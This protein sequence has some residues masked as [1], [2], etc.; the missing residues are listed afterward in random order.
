MS[1]ELKFSVADW[2]F[3]NGN[4]DRLSCYK[5]MAEA[6]FIFLETV[7]EARWNIAKSAGLRILNTD[8]PGRAEGINDP[9]YHDIMI[10]GIKEAIQKAVDNEIPQLILFEGKKIGIPD[11]VALEN[12]VACLRKIVPY[13][14]EAGIMLA[15]ELSNSF[16]GDNQSGSIAYGINMARQ[17]DSPFFKI[18]YCTYQ[19]NLMKENIADDLVA[20]L[21]YIAH[22]HVAGAADRC[23]PGPGSGI[24]YDE[25]I[26][27]V[28]NAGYNGLWGLE[29]F[30]KGD[31]IED[32]IKIRDLFNSYIS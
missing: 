12:S 17:V 28:Y 30:P 25:I 29:F 6:G 9:A 4:T 13:A 1:S 19:R 10:T 31:D 15:I 2:T 16:E 20:N 3:Y 7:Q 8:A 11:E 23:Y 24:P 18:I 27:K 26:P 5:K 32:L 21:D 14:E 22:I